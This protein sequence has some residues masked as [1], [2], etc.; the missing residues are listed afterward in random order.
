M[1]NYKKFDSHWSFFSAEAVPQRKIAGAYSFLRPAIDICKEK[2]ISLLDAGCGNCVHAEVLKSY[3]FRDGSIFVGLDISLSGI[4]LD[5]LR[6][7]E[8]LFVN[9]DVA[10]MPFADNSFDVVFSFGV[11]GYTDN[12]RKS[13]NELCRV[14]EKGGLLGVWL[15][16]R[17][18]GLAEKLFTATRALCKLIGTK[19]AGIIANLIVPFLIFLPTRS[20]INILNA[21]WRQ[22]YEVVMVNINPE[23]LVFFERAEVVKWFEE[24]NIK[25]V[26]EDEDNAITIW[27]RKE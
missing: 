14:V 11:L 24:N 16:P 12:P 13:F 5:S 6:H 4:Q 15:Y 3:S 7:P 2:K 25:I 26:A 23:R 19:G 22:C 17:K 27:G 1:N 9:A 18:K 21:T 10:R 20:K 8:W